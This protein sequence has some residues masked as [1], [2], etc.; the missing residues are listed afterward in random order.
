M[1]DLPGLVSKVLVKDQR[2]IL[3]LLWQL[4]LLA[5]VGLQLTGVASCLGT[6]LTDGIDTEPFPSKKIVD[7]QSIPIYLCSG[8]RPA[9]CF[10]RLGVHCARLFEYRVES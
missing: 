9:E 10:P 4:D 6:V 1:V 5:G 2:Q 8:L 7:C 3:Q